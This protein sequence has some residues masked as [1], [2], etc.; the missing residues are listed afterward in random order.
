MITAYIRKKLRSL[1]E[2]KTS[3]T[4]EEVNSSKVNKPKAK[5]KVKKKIDK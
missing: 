2:D 1:K 5:A 4:K 3:D